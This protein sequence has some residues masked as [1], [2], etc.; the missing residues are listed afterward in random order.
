MLQFKNLTL[1]RGLKLLFEQASL[2]V[3]PGQKIGIT[4][5]N[6]TGKSSLF[7]LILNDL[8]AD[9]LAVA[10]LTIHKGKGVHLVN[11]LQLTIGKDITILKPLDVNRS[12]NH[13]MR[14]VSG[15]IRFHQVVSDQISF[16]LFR[17]I[18]SKDG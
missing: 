5:A 11:E 14:I 16:D 6:G 3:H 9:G 15:E 17:P 2:Q 13:A 18:R 10:L 4:G 12:A 1:R 7:A 8:H